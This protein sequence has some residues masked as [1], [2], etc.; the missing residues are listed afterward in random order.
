[1]IRTDNSGIAINYFNRKRF[2]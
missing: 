2:R 1:M